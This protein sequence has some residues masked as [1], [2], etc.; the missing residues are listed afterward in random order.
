[1]APASAFV[2][3]LLRVPHRHFV[4]SVFGGIAIVNHKESI[5]FGA[6]L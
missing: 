1:M 2:N 4:A 5:A 3:N 6:K